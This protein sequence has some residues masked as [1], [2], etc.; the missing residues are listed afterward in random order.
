MKTLN[1]VFAPQPGR[2][3]K[4]QF[5]YFQFGGKKIYGLRQIQTGAFRDAES[6]IA[7]Y[8]Y[9]FFVGQFFGKIAKSGTNPT[10]F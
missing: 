1:P 10:T 3:L 9:M 4:R 5:L 8:T 7:R 6:R 2:T